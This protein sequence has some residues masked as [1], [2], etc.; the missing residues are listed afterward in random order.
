[1]RND[2]IRNILLKGPSVA[3]WLYRDDERRIYGDIDLLV[4]PGEFQRAE[5]LLVGLHSAQHG[6]TPTPLNDLER[7]LAQVP[8][9]TWERAG[10][11][12]RHLRA[13]GSFRSGLCL[14]PQGRAVAAEL[15]LEGEAPI[16]AR[17]KADDAP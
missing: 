16:E 12:A 15:A 1:M 10:A 9:S 4:S 7:A 6:P 11:L 8:L 14:L 13:E 17:I 3:R 5:A 2:G